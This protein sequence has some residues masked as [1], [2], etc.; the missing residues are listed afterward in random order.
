MEL[1]PLLA[2]VFQA[3]ATDLYL[4]PGAIPCM[5][6]HG[7]F[8]APRASGGQRLM[9][10][11]TEE[12]ARQLMTAE[13]WERFLGTREAN[14]AYM[15]PTAGRFRVNALWQRGTVG[16]VLRRV[17]ME[18]PTLRQLGL[19]P[20]LRDI[21]LADRGI[22]LVTGS[23]GSG[24]STSMASMIDYRNHLRSGHIV[25]IEDPIEFVYRHR[26][27]IVT[28]REVGMDTASFE[29]A[30]RNSLRQA[31]QVISIGEMRDAETVQFAM[32]ASETGHLVFATLHS[33]NATMAVER[34]V[35]FYPGEQK[36]QVQLQLSMNLK[37]IICQRLVPRIGGGRCC[38]CEILV[39]TPHLQA[40]IAKGDMGALKMAMGVENSEGIQTFDKSLYKLFKTKRI[41]PEDALASS[42]SQNDLQMKMRGIG[43]EPGSS[44]EDLSDPWANVQEDFAVPPGPQ[45]AVARDT[46]IGGGYSNEAAPPMA[47]GG[48]PRAAMAPPPAPPPRPM[49]PPAPAVVAGSFP[50]Q[51]APAG[52]S[53]A[54]PPS[55]PV[56]PRPQATPPRPAPAPA[57]GAGPRSVVD[58]YK[59]MINTAMPP[60]STDELDPDLEL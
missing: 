53:Q 14:V 26:R 44:W 21:S 55:Q 40:L 9:P 2:E 22:V 16:L 47:G 42:D 45:S 8:A 38:A 43:I 10:N 52:Q 4:I 58:R 35:H 19:P 23:T 59:E 27:S 28:Q 7:S 49:P 6:M 60:S 3:R 15:S 24:K 48:A 34:L 41:S 50:F 57:P 30:L 39:N 18:I 36:E 32:H 5:S 56:P 13:Q 46:S 29:E 17:V 25:T 12:F 31:P 37:A 54:A 33:T 11:Q 51:Q 20:I 1:E